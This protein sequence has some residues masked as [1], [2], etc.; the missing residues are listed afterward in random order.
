MFFA[1]KTKT[2]TAAQIV[3]IQ[4]MYSDGVTKTALATMYGVTVGMISRVINDARY[5]KLKRSKSK[6]I[7]LTVMQATQIRGLYDMG[8]ASTYTIAKL[9]NVSPSLVMNIIQNKTWAD[10]C[11]HPI[12]KSELLKRR[13][14][15][16]ALS[17]PPQQS[18]A[19]VKTKTIIKTVPAK[20]TKIDIP[21]IMKDG[22]IDVDMTKQVY[23]TVLHT[24]RANKLV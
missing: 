21:L 18:Q 10:P 9:F 22:K 11:Y 8:A 16:L 12:S 3:D 2:L 13:A 19:Q 6:K 14:C 20:I 1:S 5:Y 23:E 15:F 17:K 24:L 4:R 7:K